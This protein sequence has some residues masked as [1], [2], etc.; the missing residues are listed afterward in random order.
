MSRPI[1]MKAMSTIRSSKTKEIAPDAYDELNEDKLTI[2]KMLNDKVNS[3]LDK[4]NSIK[5]RPKQ[6]SMMR[7]LFTPSTVS[8]KKC[9]I[10][11]FRTRRISMS[12]N[13]PSSDIHMTRSSIIGKK[14]NSIVQNSS[15]TPKMSFF[16]PMSSKGGRGRN[17]LFKARASSLC[18]NSTD[19]STTS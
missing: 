19:V 11:N 13:S 18:H 1:P 4:L 10:A 15:I 6:D 3:K 16:K 14:H 9:A 5:S 7:S 17:H 8:N 2:F 12:S